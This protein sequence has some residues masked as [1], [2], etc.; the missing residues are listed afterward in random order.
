MFV[1]LCSVSD[2][3]LDANATG[4]PCCRSATPS[5][6]LLASACTVSGRFLL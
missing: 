5:P 6:C 1:Y 2:R 4:S 3:D